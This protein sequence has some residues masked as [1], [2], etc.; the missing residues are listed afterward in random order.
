MTLE[1]VDHQYTPQYQQSNLFFIEFLPSVDHTRK[2]IMSSLLPRLID[3][4]KQKRIKKIGAVAHPSNLSALRVL[5]K[6]GLSKK[7]SFD[8]FQHLYHN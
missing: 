8:P 4:L 2:A 7:T 6:S 3:K 5:H 1:A